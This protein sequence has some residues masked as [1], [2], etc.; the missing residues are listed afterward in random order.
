[1]I[2]EH[3]A[4]DHSYTVKINNFADWH[5]EDFQNILIDR[6]VERTKFME[7]GKPVN[8]T[9]KSSMGSGTCVNFIDDG[10]VTGVKN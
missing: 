10:C 7:H 6:E 3:N 4:G 2:N 1:M 8:K 5:P 9:R